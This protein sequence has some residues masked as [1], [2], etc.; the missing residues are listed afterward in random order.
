MT[1][2]R[3][4]NTHINKTAEQGV[5]MEDYEITVTDNKTG[6]V[7]RTLTF[8]TARQCECKF[9]AMVANINLNDYSVTKTGLAK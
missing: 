3:D 2:L 8:L 4:N 7:V 5:N 1:W 9:I 6:E